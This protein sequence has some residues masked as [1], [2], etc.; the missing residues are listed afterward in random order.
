[1]TG[2]PTP[3]QEWTLSEKLDA[4]AEAGFD[5]VCWAPSEELW[6]GVK[7]RGLIFVGGMAGMGGRTARGLEP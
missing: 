7:T 4:I 6:E 3:D 5:A 1:M 2:H